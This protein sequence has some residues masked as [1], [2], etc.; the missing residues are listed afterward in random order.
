VKN[1]AS[2]ANTKW[3]AAKKVMAIAAA[4]AASAKADNQTGR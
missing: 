3:S 1:F 2:H 4:I